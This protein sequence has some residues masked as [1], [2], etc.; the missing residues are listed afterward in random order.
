M[1]DSK[2][3][4]QK[5]AR[6][7][8][9]RGRRGPSAGPELGTPGSALRSAASPKFSPA[10]EGSHPQVWGDAAV[11]AFL[12]R[13]LW[14]FLASAVLAF[15]VD[16]WAGAFAGWNDEG[17]HRYVASRIAEGEALYRDVHSARPPFVIGSLALL[18]LLGLPNL[19]AAKLLVLGT[20]LGTAGLLFW[21]GSRL[22]SA[23]AAACAAA[24][25]LFSAQT[26]A[27]S[28]YTG[29]QWVAFGGA[30]L[31]C[32]ALMGRARA[33]GLA[34]AFALACG[35]H[36]AVLAGLVPLVFF[37]RGG[38]SAW[39][40]VVRYGLWAL[41]PLA[42]VY[43]G[44]FYLGGDALFHDLVG[45]HLYHVTGGKTSSQLDWWL[46]LFGWDDSWLYALALLG[47]LLPRKGANPDP[48]RPL[49]LMAVAHL[50]VVVAMSGGLILY[51]F[52]SLPLFAWAAGAGA[53]RTWLRFET[54]GGLWRRMGLRWVAVVLSIMLIVFGFSRARHMLEARD[55]ESYALVPS[56][57]YLELSRLQ[58][59][60]AV[61]D[62]AI[63]ARALPEDQT[64]FG[65]PTLVSA[66]ALEA[67]RRVAGD[68]ADLAP[69]WFQ[70]GTV[71]REDVI[72]TIEADQVGLF[73]SHKHG[74]DRGLQGYLSR[75]YEKPAVV[76]RVRGDGHGIP[77]LYVFRH[78]EGPRP[79][80]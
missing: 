40:E 6:S 51:V 79:C 42:I 60:T 74:I 25:Y 53:D 45:K 11:P 59:L 1:S 33:A 62:V 67:G 71:R 73:V 50:A 78:K 26:L 44:A 28:A 34:A 22:F 24:F 19:W 68:L 15:C 35:Q 14:G 69:R 20:H 31:V 66:V 8:S 57:R 56:L 2:R 72:A 12:P 30:L 47:L 29:I 5:R 77:D 41:A 18:L 7:P 9:P 21:G 16:S 37:W 10:P 58:K 39:R 75:C 65:Y 76:P 43:G 38:V 61:E 49:F 64:L 70:T 54:G 23:R 13:W 4:A 32:F 63:F 48:I 46:A 52:P 80:L 55:N 27:R 17:I 36:A 3:A